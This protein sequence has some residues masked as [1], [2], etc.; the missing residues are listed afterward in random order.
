MN[1]LQETLDGAFSFGGSS[2]FGNVAL[3]LLLAFILG[4]VLAWLYYMT[5]NGLSYS[6][7]FVQSLVV[8][9][10]VVSII[11]AVIGDNIVTAFG[12]MGALAIIR[13]RNVIKDTRD[14][15]YIFCALVVGMAAGSQRYS[16]AILGTVFICM[17]NLYLHYTNFGSRQPHNGFLRFKFE[18][19]VEP[20]HQISST[21]KRF[22]R[23]FVLISA[24]QSAIDSAKVE[25]SYQL[26]IRN[27][28]KNERLLAE[29]GNIEG[30]DDVHLT[31]QEQLLEI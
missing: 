3:S 21:L 9:T 16:I 12:L 11:M 22:C 17:L 25:Y 31:M 13:F 20:G 2:D 7:T 28:K 23:K 4:Q 19:H 8:I 5:H 14:I 6:R 15:V 1:N 10:V 24:Q 30:L 26:S 27:S 29:L 18:G